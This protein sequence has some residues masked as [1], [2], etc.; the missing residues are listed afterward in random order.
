MTHVFLESS[1]QELAISHIKMKISHTSGMSSLG[2][3]LS[4]FNKNFTLT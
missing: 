1:G 2:Y 4:V 3:P